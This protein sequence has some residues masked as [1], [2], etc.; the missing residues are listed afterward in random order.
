LLQSLLQLRLA[1]AVRL[2]AEWLP[3]SS[4]LL[5]R[6]GAVHVEPG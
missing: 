2:R 3:L 5:P 1:S 4:R 6:A